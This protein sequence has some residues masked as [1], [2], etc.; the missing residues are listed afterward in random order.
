MQSL[1]AALLTALAII[2][3]LRSEITPW[4]IV[5]KADLDANAAKLAE[6]VAVASTSKKAPPWMF[7]PAYRTSLEKT[8]VI[9]VPE[10]S[11]SRENGRTR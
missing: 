7:D 3:V 4:R 9:G 10:S 6:A 2:S 5:A 1:A 8:T 11:H